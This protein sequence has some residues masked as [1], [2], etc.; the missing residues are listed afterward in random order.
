MILKQSRYKR[1]PVLV[2]GGI[3]GSGKTGDENRLKLR[4]AAAKALEHAACL[5]VPVYADPA[6]NERCYGDLQVIYLQLI[7]LALYIIIIIHFPLL[8]P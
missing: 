1:V 3:H 7:Y 4:E 2:R 5:T 8:V 6:L